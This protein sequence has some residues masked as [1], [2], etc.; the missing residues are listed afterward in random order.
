M[1]PVATILMHEEA[2]GPC[3]LEPALRRAGFELL[4]RYRE[5]RRGDEASELVVVMGGAMAV[6][7]ADRH[8]FLSAELELLRRRLRADQPCLGICLGA[9]RLAAGA[10]A[11]VH[12][13]L[14]G[15]ELGAA[16]VEVTAEGAADPIFQPL[17][18]RAVFA[19]WHQDTF[20]PVPG[21]IRLASTERYA[22][23]AFKLGCSYGIQFHPEVDAEQFQR[24]IQLAPED[25]RRA[26]RTEE[27]IVEHDLPQLRRSH[28]TA[29]R[30]LDRLATHFAGVCAGKGK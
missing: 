13:G 2:E 18:P 16:P 20:D 10:G 4:C 11:S 14:K 26:E 19:H 25:V 23:Q 5:V 21:G 30:L 8:P 29:L 6:Y 9:Q 12:P 15:L 24:W 7:E 28:L 22:Q 17:A 27:E 3:D 1:K